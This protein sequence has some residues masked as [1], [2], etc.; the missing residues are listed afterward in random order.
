[1]V[2]ALETQLK[3]KSFTTVDKGQTAVLY[4]ARNICKIA[5]MSLFESKVILTQM[6]MEFHRHEWE[7]TE[8]G[9]SQGEH[10]FSL[11][12]SNLQ[13]FIFN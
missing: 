3:T 6:Y 9:I 2:G 8:H 4:T 10:H 13:F 11:I 7:N 1:M 12:L 5:V